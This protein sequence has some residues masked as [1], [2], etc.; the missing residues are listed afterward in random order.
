VDANV[1]HGNIEQAKQRIAELLDEDALTDD[2]VKENWLNYRINREKEIDVSTLNFDT[3]QTKYRDSQFKNLEVAHLRE[4]IEKKLQELLVVNITK[5]NF[6]E[7]L[8]GIINQYNSGGRTTEQAFEDLNSFK[9]DLAQEEERHIAEGLTKEELEL[10]DLLY[11]E[12]LTADE[13]IKVK[14]A[15]K[16]LLWKL[17]KLSAEK[18]FWYKD[19]QEQAQVKGLIMNALNDDLPDSYDKPI[20]NK[21]CDD[22]YN[23][24]YERTL[25]SGMRFIIRFCRL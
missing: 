24:V 17:R 10:F 2:K 12:K 3:L 23:L 9:D 4:F 8:Q 19:T 22:T 11:K 16:A 7:R 13:C 21:K 18:P 15:A 6:V 25:S 5:K 20:F 14:N 1:D